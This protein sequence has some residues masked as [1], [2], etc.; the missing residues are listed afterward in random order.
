MDRVE[1]RLSQL[2]HVSE[3]LFAANDKAVIE[4]LVHVKEQLGYSTL[5]GLIASSIIQNGPSYLI[6]VLINC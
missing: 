6:N 3:W 2:L 4:F 1:S 5:G